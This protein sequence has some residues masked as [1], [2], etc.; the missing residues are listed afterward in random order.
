MNSHS[1]PNIL[2]AISDDQSSM[3]TAASGA[4]FVATPAFD[5]IA[6]EGVLFNNAFCSA[7]Q[8]SPSRAAILTGRNIWQLEEAGTHWSSFPAKYDVYPEIL[9]K[10]GYFA[11]F[12]GKP[13]APG[14]FGQRPR[15]PAG[16]EFNEIR[17]V[18]PAEHISDKDY[19]E[20]FRDFLS[21]RPENTPFVF[22]YGGHE[23]HRAYQEGIGFEAGKKLT[24]VDMRSMPFLPDSDVVRSDI[25][26]YGY[27]IEWFDL[28]LSRMIEQLQ[29]IDELDN[30]VIVVTSDNGFPFPRAKAN[31]YESS[32]RVPLAIRFPK[33]IPGNRVIDD[34][35]NLN[36][37]APTFLEFAGVSPHEG[38]S[39]TSLV[40][41]LTSNRSG[42]VDETRDRTFFGRERHGHARMNHVGYPSRAIRTREFLYIRNFASDRWPV[43]DPPFYGDIDDGPSK[44]YMIDHRSENSVKELFVLGFEKRS[45]EELYEI[46]KDPGCLVNIADRPEFSQMK[47][48]LWVDL[49]A[50]LSNHGDPRVT[51]NGDVWESYPRYGPLKPELAGTAI[52][53][54]YNEQY[55]H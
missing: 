50:L 18:P 39:S 16:R 35:V 2:L 43:G 51:G 5:R 33:H 48:S 32:M 30:T 40:N 13:W 55:R 53:G 26:D 47:E 17:T 7:P 3:H 4:R 46:N 8:C 34:I 15:N 29:K 9:E 49:R 10:N 52:Q 20:N 38:M 44:T 6:R 23:P 37:L 42:I 21:A 1:R 36:E 14:D 31:L 54:R 22:W 19:A 12:T 27:E 41:V 24:D 28:H 25:L 11:G 45:H